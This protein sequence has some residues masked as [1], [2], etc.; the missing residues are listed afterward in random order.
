MDKQYSIAVIAD[1]TGEGL[2]ELC[3]DIR[4]AGGEILHKFI[5]STF[6]KLVVVTTTKDPSGMVLS[7]YKQE[8]SAKQ[9]RDAICLAEPCY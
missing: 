4:S 6:D 2:K 8:H 7:L 5:N 1:G 3:A 9:Y